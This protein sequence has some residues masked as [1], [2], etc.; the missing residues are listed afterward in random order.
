M[1]R[2]RVAQVYMYDSLF[3]CFK[4]SFLIWSHTPCITLGDFISLHSML[5]CLIQSDLVIRKRFPYGTDIHDWFVAEKTSPQVL[6]KFA[7]TYSNIAMVAQWSLCLNLGPNPMPS[8]GGGQF[9]LV[10]ERKLWGFFYIFAVLFL[11]DSFLPILN[12]G[13]LISWFYGRMKV[14]FLCNI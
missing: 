5:L 12:I 2:R 6:V 7:R 9:E 8:I 11:S 1:A 13:G 10:N 4:S 3:F 14:V